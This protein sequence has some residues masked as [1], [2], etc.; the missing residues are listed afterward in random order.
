M[1]EAPLTRAGRREWAGLAV[2]ALPTMLIGLDMTVLHLAAPALA[3]SLRP[4]SSELLWIVDSYGFLVAGFLITMGTVGDRIGARKLL[5]IGAAAFGLA[6]L[7]AAYAP[8]TALLIAARAL[9]GVAGATLMPSTLALIRNMFH[10]RDQRRFAIAV[11]MTNFLVGGAIGPLVG[12]VLLEHFWWGSVFLVGV[13]LP[14]VL[15]IAGPLLLPEHRSSAPGRVAPAGVLLSTSAIILIV[16]GLKEFARDGLGLA[17]VA[18][19]VL[20]VVLGTVFA[21]SQLRSPAPLLDL[22]LFRRPAF[23]VALSGQTLGLYVQTG[24][25]FLVL[26]YAQLVLGMSPLQAGVAVLPAMVAG[27]VGTLLAPAAVRWTHPVWVMTGGFG[28]AAVG[29]V[30]IALA[31][32]GSPM[33]FAGTGFALVSFGVSAALALTNDFIIGSASRERAGSAASIGE[34]GAE[35][36]NALGVAMAGTITTAVYRA[37]VTPETLP[38]GLPPD[39]V[40]AA[41]DTLGGAASVAGDQP[42]SVGAELMDVARAAFT[43]GMW[44]A[45]WANVAVL[46]VLCIATAALLRSVQVPVDV[47]D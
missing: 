12:G 15:L 41:R 32:A 16:Y 43:H 30:V 20:G 17:P 6:S 19:V 18:T 31:G 24:I 28:L 39:A 25:Q 40:R 10:D 46:I 7:L 21:R 2:L 5:L 27:V 4:G 26:Q 47:D 38:A 11:W 22:A 3:E 9:L 1:R 14:L 45:S 33:A 34:T 44:V 37:Q 36:G 42:G 35:L 13:P 8:S 23:G 29:S